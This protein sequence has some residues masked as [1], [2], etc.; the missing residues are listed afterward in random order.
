MRVALVI[1]TGLV[2]WPAFLPPLACA[3]TRTWV[4]GVGD[5]FNPCARTA[6]CKTFAGAISKTAA[7]GEINCTDPGGFGAVTITKSITIDCEG[8]FGSINAAGTNGIVVNAAGA[9]VKLR[10]ISIT[11]SGSGLNGIRFLQ[12]AALHVENLRIYDFTQKAIDFEPTTSAALFVG[13]TR[14]EDNILTANGGGI[15]IKPAAGIAATA[16]LSNVRLERNTFGLRVE[17]SSVVGINDS[18]VAG[19]TNGIQ[20]VSGVVSQIVVGDVKVLNNTA[21]GLQSSGIN[22]T[23][24]VGGSVISGNGNGIAGTNGKVL[25]LGDNLISGNSTDGAPTGS[26]TPK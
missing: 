8:T 17:N 10:N 12:G 21:N 1:L 13:N 11:G 18:V 23:I 2:F 24:R 4:S 6:P 22:A 7:G 5:D 16:S 9:V 14:I 3:Q 19:N 20:L 25:S 15:F 26:I